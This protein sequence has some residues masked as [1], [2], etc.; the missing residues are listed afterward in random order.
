MLRFPRRS[1]CKH[2]N[3]MLVLIAIFKLGQAVLFAAI[4]V[5][6][7]RLLHKDV[8]D[9]LTAFVE[10]LRFNPE[11]KFINFLLAQADQLDDHRLRLIGSAAFLYAALDTAEGVG[12]YLEKTWAEYLTLL[13]TGSFLPLEILEV[14]HRQT[15]IRIGLLAANALVFIYLCKLVIGKRRAKTNDLPPVESTTL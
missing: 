6:A 12:L 14:V 9:L 8:G 13:I 4:G 5:G 2:H 7:F 1:S 10:H 11:S 3:S 15:P